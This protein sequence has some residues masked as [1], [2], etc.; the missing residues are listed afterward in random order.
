M[1]SRGNSKGKLSKFKRSKH[2]RFMIGRKE[3]KNMRIMK[4]KMMEGRRR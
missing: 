2:G 1:I 3:E 4:S